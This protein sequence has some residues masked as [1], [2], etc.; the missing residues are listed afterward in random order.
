[1]SIKK[2]ARWKI[3]SLLL[4]SIAAL[5]LVAGCDREPAGSGC[6][7]PVVDPGNDDPMNSSGDM[8]PE[9]ANITS[10]TPG[11]GPFKVTRDTSGRVKMWVP[12]VPSGCK[13]PIVHLANGTGAACSMY[14]TALSNLAEYGFLAI[15]YENTNTGQGTQ[16]ITAVETAIQEH[17]NI[18]DGNKLGF[19]G[20]SQGGGAAFMGVYRA[21][22]KWGMSKTYSGLAIE[23]ASGFGDSPANWASLYR[24]IQSP[25]SM[26]NG[27]ADILVP[28]TWVR[29]AYNALPYNNFKFWYTAVGAMHIPVP[30]GP[31][32]TMSIPWFRWTLLGDSKACQAFKALPNGSGWRVAKSA[33]MPACD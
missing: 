2:D 15:C 6:D 25:M 11:R 8:C 20:H 21:E 19:T 7:D 23:P 12:N 16:A 28:A 18:A 32:R 31:T 13:V 30:N 1:M 5:M 22:Q 4:M 33:N 29:S 14:G 9:L 10:Y 17:G 24:Q 27:T 26:F 3:V